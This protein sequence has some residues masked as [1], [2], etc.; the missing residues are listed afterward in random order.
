MA[1]P[2][3]HAPGLADRSHKVGAHLWQIPA[4][5]ESAVRTRA[6]RIHGEAWCKW[7]P[8]RRQAIRP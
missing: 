6:R 2:P 7:H 1:D 4:G 8:G 5:P 3:V